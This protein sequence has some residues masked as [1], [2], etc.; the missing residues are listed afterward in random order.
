M[1]TTGVIIT[2]LLSCV[3]VKADPP[4]EATKRAALLWAYQ[5]NGNSMTSWTAWDYEKRMR[6]DFYP[7]NVTPPVPPQPPIKDGEVR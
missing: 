2:C 4:D 7:R 5:A 1:R 3:P 6:I